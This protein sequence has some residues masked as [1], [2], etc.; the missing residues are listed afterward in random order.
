[1]GLY[2]RVKDLCSEH[3]TNV[4]NLEKLL[5]FPRSSICKWNVNIPSIEKVKRV[6]DALNEPIEKIVGDVEFHEKAEVAS[7]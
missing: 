7:E 2:E 6:A 5:G 1:M 4:Y 3:D